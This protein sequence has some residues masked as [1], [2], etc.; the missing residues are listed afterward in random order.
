MKRSEFLKSAMLAGIGVTVLPLFSF[1]DDDV[2][3]LR[4]IETSC[5]VRHGMY[6]AHVK[7]I[8]VNDRLTHFQKDVFHQNGFDESCE[9]DMFN[10][11]FHLNGKEVSIHVLG[12]AVMFNI[13]GVSEMHQVNEGESIV[14]MNAPESVCQ[15]HH[16]VGNK[17]IEVGQ[18]SMIQPLNK[19]VQIGGEL[20]SVNEIAH[21]SERKSVLVNNGWVLEFSF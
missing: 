17:V 4:G 6:G 11:S 12:S 18:E 20:C 19:E 16:V 5:H 14:L 3:V 7:G 9:N 1:T 10:V 21:L 13:D 15:L 2:V 8:C